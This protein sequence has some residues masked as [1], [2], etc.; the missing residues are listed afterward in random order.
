MLAGGLARKLGQGLAHAAAGL[1]QSVELAADRTVPPAPTWVRHG[2]GLWSDLDGGHTLAGNTDSGGSDVG[3][4]IEEQRERS[5]L[6]REAAAG[7]AGMS[8]EYLAY[9]ETSPMSNPTQAS[10]MRL[11]AAMGESPD[12][13]T[14][15]GLNAP[16]G[17]RGPG[18]HPALEK[19]SADEC[20]AH[21]APGGVGRFL[22]DADR[23]PVAVPVNYRMLGDD[24][25]FRTDDS[26]AAAGAVGQEKVSFDVDHIDE[27]LSEG[28][29]VLLSG[30]ATILTRPEDLHAAAELHIEPWAGARDTFVRIV[31]VEI[32][33]RR[34][35]V[36]AA[37]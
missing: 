3:R 16:P 4:R 22:F 8:P 33:G 30:T 2:T 18:Q 13:F 28:W 26:T 25:V 15:A 9:L 19:M 35:R 36:R 32:T 6:S 5:G 34:I 24:V 7:R 27:S 20:R 10:L 1:A 11:A 37:P 23:G 21:L 12:V 31:P 14:G 29:S 17:Q